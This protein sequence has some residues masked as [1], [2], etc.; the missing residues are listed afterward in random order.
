[1][2]RRTRENASVTQNR[3]RSCL[4]FLRPRRDGPN[5][6]SGFVVDRPVRFIGVGRATHQRRDYHCKSQ[7]GAY[8]SE[9]REGLARARKDAPRRRQADRNRSERC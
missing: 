1:L 5:H 6:E 9:R 4:P 2:S 8:G 7:G 3:S